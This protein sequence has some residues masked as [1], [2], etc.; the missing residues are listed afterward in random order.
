MR[1]DI[2]RRGNANVTHVVRADPGMHVVPASVYAL[3]KYD[4]EQLCL[5]FGTAYNISTVAP[6]LPMDL[7]RRYPIHGVLAILNFS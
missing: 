7:I 6:R 2:E 4:Q 3:S 1:A 5:M